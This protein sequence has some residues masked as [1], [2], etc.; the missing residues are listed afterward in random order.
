MAQLGWKGSAVVVMVLLC[1]AGCH[2]PDAYVLTSD[3]SPPVE[4]LFTL[5][6]AGDTILPA[7]GVSAVELVARVLDVSEGLPVVLFTTN[8]GT[9]RLGSSSFPDSALVPVDNRGEARIELVSASRE[10]IVQ[11]RAVVVDVQPKLEQELSIRFLPV[12]H[13]DILVFTEAPDSAYAH[14]LSLVPF[15]VQ[16]APELTGDHRRVHFETTGGI[17]AFAPEDTLPGARQNQV[18]LAD[19]QGV[20]TAYLRSPEQVGE[21][22]V[23]A[24][25][26]SFTQ[27]TVIRFVPAPTDSVLQF[28]EGVEAALADGQSLSRFAVQIS[29]WLQ[30]DADRTVEFS[31]TAGSFIVGGST[32]ATTSI[33]AD[34]NGVATAWLRSPARF[35]EAIVRATVKGFVQQQTLRFDWAGPDSIIVSRPWDQAGLAADKQMR[36]EAQLRRLDGRSKVTEDLEVSFAVADTLGQPIPRMR[37]VNVTR[38]NPEGQVS[39]LLLGGNTEYRG[40]AVVS[41]R[42]IRVVPDVVGREEVMILD[43]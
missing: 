16:L 32:A 35:D 2:D 9:L 34:A 38:A 42:A 19:D 1:G 31:T 26:G 23:R 27:E 43:P 30:R 6:A 11:V 40:R 13:G 39:A 10:A 28:V 29:P 21:A 5:E 22:M 24:T 36:I 20:A 14:G 41:V 3:R 12:A 8:A 25:A 18:V 17:F 7:D 4:Q 15:T 33:R 37:F